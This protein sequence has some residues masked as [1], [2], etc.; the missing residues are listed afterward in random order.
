MAVSLDCNATTLLDTRV[1]E[2]MLRYLTVE[3]GN[4]GS[5]THEFGIRAQRPCSEPAIKSRW[6]CR[7]S[8]TR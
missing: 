3:F 2:A 8:A 5:R 1:Q 6:W 7:R 4:A